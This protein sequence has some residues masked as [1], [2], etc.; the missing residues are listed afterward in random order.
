MESPKPSKRGY[1]AASSLIES[2]IAITIIT[3]CLLVA[4]KL[5]ITIL[6]G[7]PSINN[8]RLKFHVDKLVAEMK[9][10]P[11]FDSELY[12]FKTYKIKKTVSDHENQL[13]L[14]KVSYTIQGQSDTIT[15]HYLIIKEDED[16][17]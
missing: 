17:P 8:H 6:E 2:V 14:K 3:I 10:T 1:I 4:L 5:Y 13:H 11:N 9:L 7:R 15:Y 12:D 16:Q